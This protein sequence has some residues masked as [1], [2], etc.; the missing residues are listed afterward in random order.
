MTTTPTDD[1]P[2]ARMPRRRS[3]EAVFGGTS[4]SRLPARVEPEAHSVAD[5][6]PPSIGMI[7]PAVMGRA[8]DMGLI[9]KEMHQVGAR[10]PAK[11][12][13]QA[14]RR[15]GIGSTTDLL[16]FALASVA[17]EDNFA[18]AFAN[19]RGKLDPDLDIGL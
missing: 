14:K 11:L 4:S 10:L 2:R 15:T 13:E 1:R 7:V 5:A 9:S 6:C 17:V 12:L 18:N 19:A 16:A 3:V 8:A